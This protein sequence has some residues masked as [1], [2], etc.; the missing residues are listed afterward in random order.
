MKRAFQPH[1]YTHSLHRRLRV[2]LASLYGYNANVAVLNVQA[3]LQR[4]EDWHAGQVGRLGV[5]GCMEGGD[6][7]SF[8]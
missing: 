6:V 7:N 8:S 2:A 4:R 3:G 1:A 5:Q